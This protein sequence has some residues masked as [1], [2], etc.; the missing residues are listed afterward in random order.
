MDCD[1]DGRSLNRRL[2]R[3][4]GERPGWPDE[5]RQADSGSRQARNPM[6]ANRRWAGGPR[7]AAI[8][9]TGEKRQKLLLLK[10]SFGHLVLT[11]RRC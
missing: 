7:D 8:A 6:I 2:E 11:L 3:V 4:A 5:V 10:M 9:A 1:L